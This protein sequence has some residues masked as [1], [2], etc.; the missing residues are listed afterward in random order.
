MSMQHVCWLE[1]YVIHMHTTHAH[2][3]M[4]TYAHLCIITGRRNCLLEGII[5]VETFRGFRTCRRNTSALRTSWGAMTTGLR[6]MS[7]HCHDNRIKVHE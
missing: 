7:E 4:H 5:L 2:T 1:C 6:Y 3:H